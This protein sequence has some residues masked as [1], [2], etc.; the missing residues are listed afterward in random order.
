MTLRAWRGPG[1]GRPEGI[2]LPPRRMPLVRGGRVLK[3]WRYVGVHAPELSL[4]AAVV[5]LG[6]VRHAFWAVWER[7]RGR[8]TE[9]TVPINA[10]TVRLAPGRVRVEDGPS[11]I[12][13]GL[14]ER[15][16]VEVVTP[17]GAGYAWTA[18]QGD[19][20]AHG[21]LTVAGRTRAVEGR[22]MIDD[23][24]GY[25]PR[26]TVWRWCSGVGT[27]TDG[28]A[29]AWNLVDGVHDDPAAS[30]RTLWVD[31]V[32]REL[33]PVR[34]AGDL[35]GVRFAEGGELRFASEAVRAQ[36]TSLGVVRSDYEQPFGSFSGTLP[37]G[38]ELASGAGVMERHDALW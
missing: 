29:L 20:R 23:W 10:R 37:G 32:A 6:P 2:P 13:L 3:R 22:A 14:E 24:A 25:P 34:F 9:R 8:L 7:D 19:V 18:K 16:P 36:R 28:R 35:E 4:C 15:E 11:A 26:R 17:Y 38:F 5:Q 21:A 12:Y 31:G 27:A 30:E 33:G 1:P